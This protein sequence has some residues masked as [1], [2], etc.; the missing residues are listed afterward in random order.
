MQLILSTANALLFADLLDNT[1][2]IDID[3][4]NGEIHCHETSALSDPQALFQFLEINNVDGVYSLV[5]R[6]CGPEYG[7]REFESPKLALEAADQTS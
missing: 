7:G 5:V 4:V 2:E 3:I 6:A 1:E